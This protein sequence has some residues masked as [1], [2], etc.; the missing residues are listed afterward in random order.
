M[1]GP[2]QIR[3]EEIEA[4]IGR[5][6]WARVSERVAEDVSYTVGAGPQ[7]RGVDGLRRYMEA[8]A[9][10]FTWTGH[11]EELALETGQTL[12]MEVTSHLRRIADGAAV[13]L[14]CTDIYR[15]RDDLLFDW[16]VYADLGAIGLS[17]RAG[18]EVS[19]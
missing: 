4:A 6:D 3:V 9:R 11:D 17:G 13:T 8:Q 19:A 10:A 12:V 1:K 16:R 2:L 15:F 7:R 14:P 18:L 5:G